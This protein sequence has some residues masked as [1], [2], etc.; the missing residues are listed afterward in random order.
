MT[1]ANL[2]AHI[3]PVEEGVCKAQ[4]RYVCRAKKTLQ[5]EEICFL[6]GYRGRLTTGEFPWKQAFGQKNCPA[7][8]IVKRN[9]REGVGPSTM[10]VSAN[11]TLRA[12][13]NLPLSQK[14]T[15]YHMNQ[16]IM[17]LPPVIREQVMGQSY[18]TEDEKKDVNL[19]PALD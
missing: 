12:R 10:E 11:V 6:I 16:S 8:T 17:H 9:A 7:G 3:D 2:G 18:D 4:E 1:L 5:C 15:L 14:V 13:K 19:Y